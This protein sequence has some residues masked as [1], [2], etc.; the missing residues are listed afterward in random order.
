MTRKVSVPY[1]F[2]DAYAIYRLVPMGL[3]PRRDDRK[4]RLHRRASTMQTQCTAS[5]ERGLGPRERDGL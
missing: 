1:N 5:H 2:Y 3:G 4:K